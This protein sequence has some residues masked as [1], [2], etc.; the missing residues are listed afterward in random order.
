M[1]SGIHPIGA[2]VAKKQETGHGWY[3]GFCS[4]ML[5]APQESRV[6]SERT[7]RGLESTDL[8]Q[9]PLAMVA[10]DRL[11]WCSWHPSS[12]SLSAHP[13]LGCAAIQASRMT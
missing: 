8:S 10:H 4:Q 7:T 1:L 13:A 9:V 2:L 12:A 6:P 5:N 3:M 11:P